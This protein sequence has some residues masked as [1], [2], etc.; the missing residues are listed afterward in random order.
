[1]LL[2]LSMTVP[3]P[4]RGVYYR[5][6]PPQGY[7]FRRHL[8]IISDKQPLCLLRLEDFLKPTAIL[9][10]YGY[11]YCRAV[12]FVF[13]VFR[14]HF[15][16]DSHN[17]NQASFKLGYLE[18]IHSQLLDLQISLF[19]LFKFT[20]ICSSRDTTGQI[21]NDRMNLGISCKPVTAPHCR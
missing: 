17:H 5:N 12:R 14:P 4:Q 13:N 9:S 16:C 1:M 2:L 10:Y 15:S 19:S 7:Y 18:S 11:H 20:R 6:L 21:T 8:C 3:Q